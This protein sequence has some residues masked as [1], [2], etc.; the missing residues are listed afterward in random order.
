MIS[1]R[2]FGHVRCQPQ[3][4]R[5]AHI[6]NGTWVW[7]QDWHQCTLSSLRWL[8][9]FWNAVCTHFYICLRPGIW[10]N[11][12]TGPSKS[13]VLSCPRVFSYTA[14]KKSMTQ[15]PAGPIYSILM[16]VSTCHRLPCTPPA[17]TSDYTSL[18]VT[19]IIPP[20]FVFI[21]ILNLHLTTLP[22]S[23]STNQRKKG[24][25]RT[26]TMNKCSAIQDTYIHVQRKRNREQKY[27]HNRKLVTSM[28]K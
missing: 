6:F 16:K 11:E 23:I 2:E 15:I 12:K 26:Q 25:T 4:G 5:I 1:T 3:S 10:V 17:L 20:L 13:L 14:R 22:F 19:N 9:G 21:L 24:T 18:T 28:W 27:S 7:W 8:S